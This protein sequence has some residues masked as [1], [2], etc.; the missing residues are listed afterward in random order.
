MLI[1]KILMGIKM[2]DINFCDTCGD[3]TNI[4]SKDNR[5]TIISIDNNQVQNVVEICPYC[6]NNLL[7]S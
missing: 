4:L 1:N 2:Q 5:T 6:L 3:P 7:N